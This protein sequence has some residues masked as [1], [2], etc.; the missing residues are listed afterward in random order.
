MNKETKKNK[1]KLRKNNIMK[2]IVRDLMTGIIVSALLCYGLSSAYEKFIQT[3]CGGKI[4][5]DA[6]NPDI[7]FTQLSLVFIVISF[8]TLL[9]NKTENVYWVDVIQY[10][11]VKPNHTSIVDIT[12]FIFANLIISIVAFYYPVKNQ[13]ILFSFLNM[14]N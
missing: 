4:L 5:I 13:M 7:L 11:L 3:V 1:I 2:R 12:T 9:A 10:R 6:N 14:L 8:V